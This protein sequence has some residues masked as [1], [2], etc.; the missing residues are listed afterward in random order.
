M[1]FVGIAL[2]TFSGVI[3]GIY[4][5]KPQTVSVSVVFLAVIA[6]MLGEG[7][8]LFIPRK[9][10]L[11]Q[12]LNPFPFNKK[13]HVAIVIMASSASISSMGIEVIAVERLF[14]GS[15]L[16]G[17]ISVF[18]LFSSQF[19]G[20]GI[21]GL[22]RGVLV[23]PKNMLWPIN[24]PVNAMLET[25]HRP[26]E[27]TRKPLKVF[28]IVFACIFC[29]EI[30][31][32]WIMPLLTGVSIFC[33]ANQSSATF[34]NIFGG[35]SGDEGLGLFSLSLDWQY[36]SGG[37]LSPLWFPM[38]SLI[39]QGFG[40]LGCIALF[41]AC[42]YGNV[43]RAQDFPFLAQ[44]IFANTSTAGNP[45][46]WNQN[47]VIGS[48]HRI[49]TEALDILGLPWFSASYAASIIATNMSTTAAFTHLCL[50]YWGDIKAAFTVF[51]PSVFRKAFD[52]RNWSLDFWRDAA[53]PA[54]NQDNYDPHYKL[55]TAYKAVPDWWFGLVLLLSCIIGITI[56]YSGHTT[57]P[58][59]GFVIAILVG[60]IFVVFLGSMMAITGV[61][62]LVQPIVQMIGGYIQPGDPVSNMYF[63]LYVSPYEDFLF[64]PNQNFYDIGL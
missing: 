36:I 31:P 39:S 28:L 20:Y 42:Y 22:M 12:F 23:Y 30:V 3:S 29:W 14:Y 57:L 38:D 21:A 13:E 55:I 7:M 32:E 47:L 26:R 63:S 51:H 61:Q 11:G 27:E 1:K 56:I 19:L 64:I 10:W 37:S 34:T 25:L 15:K 17:A 62:W 60:Y 49:N 5:F 40:I 53:V 2:S 54:Q 35:A 41:S 50:W 24:L 4:Y 8:S 18:L 43:W 44:E 58:W 16:S 9:T 48:D 46:I 59:W 33:L 52:F 6:Y 45:V